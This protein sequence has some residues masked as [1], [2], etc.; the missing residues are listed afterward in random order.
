MIQKQSWGSCLSATCP[1]L[2]KGVFGILV[3]IELVCCI[4]ICKQVDGYTYVQDQ[5]LLMNASLTLTNQHV[6][7]KHND[8]KWPEDTTVKPV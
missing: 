6:N 3:L 1:V 8:K 4:T 7:A 2:N 5:K